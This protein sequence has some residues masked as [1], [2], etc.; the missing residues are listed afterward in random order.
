MLKLNV[1]I[2][3]LI[4]LLVVFSCHINYLVFSCIIKL[5]TRLLN[6]EMITFNIVV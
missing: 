5:F 2:A 4:L 1:E 3:A 6:F